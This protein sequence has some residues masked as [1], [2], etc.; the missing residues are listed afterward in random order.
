MP[1]VDAYIDK[2]IEVMWL[3]S[4]QDPPMAIRWAKKESQFDGENYKE[5]CKKGRIVKMTVW[6]A[7]FLHEKGVLMNKGFVMP[8]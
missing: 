1:V 5:Y 7:V 4:V 2:C 3:M 8:Q 6:P